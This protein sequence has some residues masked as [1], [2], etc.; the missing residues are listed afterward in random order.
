MWGFII[1]I[2]PI[3]IGTLIA[4]LNQKNVFKNL[5]N[6]I[7]FNPIHPIPTA[8][9]FKFS[10]TT[11]QTWVIVTLKDGNTVAGL[12]GYSSFAS[13]DSTERDIYLEKVYSISE[14]QWKLVPRSDGILIRNDQVKY[15]EFF[16][17]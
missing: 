8:W 5:L 13:S 11:K 3:I 17:N 10:N 12:F 15:I 16:N 7:G 1:L 9:D 14:K 2:S 4:K 6:F